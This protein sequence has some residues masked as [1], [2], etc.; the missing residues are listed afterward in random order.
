MEEKK[1]LFVLKILG[2][3]FCLLTLLSA[4]YS[5]A[6]DDQPNPQHLNLEDLKL[7]D[8]DKN[9]AA[10]LSDQAINMVWTDLLEK[11]NQQQLL[12]SQLNPSNQLN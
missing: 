10:D 6:D 7:S 2:R 11:F 9:W 4:N 12:E 1:L 5:L 3:I 8:D